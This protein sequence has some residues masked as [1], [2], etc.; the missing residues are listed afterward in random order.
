M[1]KDVSVAVGTAVLLCALTTVSPLFAQDSILQ[2]D[3]AQSRIRF[4]LGATLHTVHGAFQLKSGVIHFNSVTG[5]ASGTILVNAA[6]GD[7][8]NGARDRDLRQKVLESG[9]YPEIAFTVERFEGRVAPQGQSDVQ[10][11]GAFSLLGSQ[12]EMTADVSLQVAGDQ[13]TAVT[14]LTIPYV[15]WGLKNPSTLFLRVRDTVDVEIQAVGHLTRTG[16]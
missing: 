7:T 5:A 12:H 3:P 9:R 11:H 2:L 10:V 15:K 16:T 8:G 4:T 14:H 13:V 6:S 1:K